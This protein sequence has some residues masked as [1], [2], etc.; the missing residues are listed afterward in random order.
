M[1]TNTNG[2]LKT[3]DMVYIAMMAALMAVCSW[4]SIPGDVPF[5]LQIFGLFC[6]LG[7]LGGKRGT[8]AVLVYLLMGAIGLPVFSG[9]SGG[10]GRLLGTTGGYLIGYIFSGLIYWLVIKLLGEKR[11]TMAVGMVLGLVVCY[12]F[13]TVWYVLVYA[14]QAEHIGFMAALMRCVIP[15]ILP[16]LIKIALALAV[17]G[18]VR[19]HV[20][21]RA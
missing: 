8:L 5:T 6:V 18:T 12:A 7:L 14:R 1:N 17:S 13:G 16:D 10:L 9:F 4:I 15:F 11:W 21:V 20:V 3:I 19:R 2:K